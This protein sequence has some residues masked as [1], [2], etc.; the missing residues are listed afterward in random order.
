M[1]G[2]REKEERRWKEQIAHVV[3]HLQTKKEAKRGNVKRERGQEK[4]E[5]DW[6]GREERRGEANQ[7][8]HTNGKR[9]INHKAQC[10]VPA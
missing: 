6:S 1:R 10:H 3:Y 9:D 8:G 7:V 5:E 4:T 2:E